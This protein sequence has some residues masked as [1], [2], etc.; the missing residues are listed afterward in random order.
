MAEWLGSGLQNHLQRFESAR[1]L[2]AS[3]ATAKG[4]FSLPAAQAFLHAAMGKEKDLERK[5][6]RL[7]EVNPLII[8]RNKVEVDN[9]PPKLARACS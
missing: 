8:H 6:L 2:K 1:D 5:A 7:C 9:P 4:A 3:F